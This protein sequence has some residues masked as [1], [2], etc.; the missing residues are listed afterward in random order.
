MGTE[1][2]SS[3]APPGPETDHA[4]HRRRS[5]CYGRPRQMADPRRTARHVVDRAAATFTSQTFLRPPENFSGDVHIRVVVRVVIRD[6]P[7]R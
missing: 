3:R 4:G 2:G 7:G 5:A 6:V 1:S